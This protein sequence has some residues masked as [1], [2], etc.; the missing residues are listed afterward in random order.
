MLGLSC[1]FASL[2]QADIAWGKP[3][4]RIRAGL[5]VTRY[6]DGGP[7][8]L[9]VRLENMTDKADSVWMYEGPLCGCQVL[10][11]FTNLAGEELYLYSPP[12][13]MPRPNDGPQGGTRSDTGLSPHQP[14][15][16]STTRAW[17]PIPSG[18]Y[19]VTAVVTSDGL[20]GT[21]NRRVTGKL[22]VRI[23]KTDV[24]PSGTLLGSR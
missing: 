21:R 8:R 5:S 3:Y 10:L 1:A 16:V 24:D 13:L 19:F 18:E 23:S 6:R 14:R 2:Q 7:V 17:L 15:I 22:R 9:T 11:T 20:S 4:D 12:A